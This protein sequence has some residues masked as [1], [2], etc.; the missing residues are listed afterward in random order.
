MR[1][2]QSIYILEEVE[3]FGTVVSVGTWAVFGIE[4]CLNGCAAFTRRGNNGKGCC[5]GA[6][7]SL[8]VKLVLSIHSDVQQQENGAILTREVADEIS[9]QYWFDRRCHLHQVLKERRGKRGVGMKE[10]RLLSG[11][12]ACRGNAQC[13]LLS[14]YTWDFE[15]TW[16]QCAGGCKNKEKTERGERKKGN[17]PCVSVYTLSS[18]PTAAAVHQTM[19]QTLARLPPHFAATVLVLWSETRL[20]QS[21]AHPPRFPFG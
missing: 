4:M 8:F 7:I 21:R 13:R 19:H 10:N 18:L 5:G 12:E 17:I 3:D 15:R 14:V 16:Q 11:L 9:A 1:S 20:G 6:G 2:M